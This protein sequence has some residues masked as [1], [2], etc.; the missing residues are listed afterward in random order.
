MLLFGFE[1]GFGDEHW[2]VSILNSDLFDFG[3]EDLLD[4]F[5]NEI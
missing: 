4:L 3:V 5:P 1:G 2:E